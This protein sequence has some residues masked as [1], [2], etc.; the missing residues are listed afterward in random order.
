MDGRF[1]VGLSKGDKKDYTGFYECT[2]YDCMVWKSVDVY[3]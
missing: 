3:M 2:I 1:W